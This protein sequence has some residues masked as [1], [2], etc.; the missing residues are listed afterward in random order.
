[1]ARPTKAHSIIILFT[2]PTKNI[3]T[4]VHLYHDEIKCFGQNKV[5]VHC[6]ECGKKHHVEVNIG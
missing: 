5:I 4:E 3:E 2:C 6:R 1:V